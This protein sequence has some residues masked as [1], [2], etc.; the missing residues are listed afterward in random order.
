MWVSEMADDNNDV[1]LFGGQAG[2]ELSPGGDWKLTVG[3][4]CFYYDN[5][6]GADVLDWQKKNSSYGN[7]TVAGSVSGGVTNKAYANG[8]A[9][10]Y[11]FASC[12]DIQFKT[13]FCET[14]ISDSE[15]SADWDR[16]RLELTVS[17]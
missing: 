15:A 3:A 14:R 16:F 17:F 1:K 4:G 11:K 6:E 8:F 10:L 9:I 13:F 5:I 12:A 2:A 7:S